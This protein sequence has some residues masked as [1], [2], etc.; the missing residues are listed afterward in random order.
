M[1]ECVEFSPVYIKQSRGYDSQ[2]YR[3]NVNSNIYL[4]WVILTEDG[5]EI[6]RTSALICV[7]IFWQGL[8]A[9]IESRIES[10]TMGHVGHI[11]QV[12]NP[13]V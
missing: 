4:Y 12:K 2:A 7:Q 3:N 5:L 13:S 9:S 11:C 1:L 10:Y 6:D 8:H